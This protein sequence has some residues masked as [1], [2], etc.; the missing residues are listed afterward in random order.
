MIVSQIRWW[1][2]KADD[3]GDGG[4]DGDDE[5]DKIKLFATGLKLLPHLSPIDRESRVF[6]SMIW[7]EKGIKPNI[8]EN[9]KKFSY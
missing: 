6:C 4:S 9:S 1:R 2:T 3:D 5:Y 7:I 8:S